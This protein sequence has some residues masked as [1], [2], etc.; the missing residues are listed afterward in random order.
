MN[1]FRWVLA[2]FLLALALLLLRAWLGLDAPLGSDPALWGLSA[3]Q[4]L[5][6][7]L[8][9]VLPGYPLMVAAASAVS[10]RLPWLVG[11]WIST[12]AGAAVP[13]LS[14][15]VARVLGLEWWAALLVGLA[16]LASPDL[17]AFSFQLQPD[18]TALLFLLLSALA[19]LRWARQPLA[20]RTLLF[21]CGLLAM[22]LV[23]E[24]GMVI[25]VATLLL[26]LS[27]KYSRVAWLLPP[28]TA[29]LLLVLVWT[30]VA[31][32]LPSRVYTPLAESP[33]LLKPGVGTSFM[34]ELTG[35]AGGSFR[36][37]LMRGD[38]L[39]IWWIF[40]RTLGQRSGDTLALL[41]LGFAGLWW[42][43]RSAQGS[44]R[45]R[46]AS[47][48][49]LLGLHAALCSPILVLLIIWSH[50]RHAA[51][52]LPL[53]YVGIAAGL[54]RLGK[55]RRWPV[56]LCTGLGLG[57]LAM[58]LPSS[59]AAISTEA[60]HAHQ[61]MALAEWMRAQPGRWFL[62]GVFN[63]INLHLLWPRNNPR[64][65]LPGQPMPRLWSGTD[66]RTM[67]VGPPGSMPP[68]FVPVHQVGG[69]VVYRLEPEPGQE[70]PCTR[71]EPV[72]SV[73]F[74][75][76]DM[77]GESSPSC[78]AEPFFGPEPGHGSRGRGA[79]PAQLRQ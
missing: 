28:A 63:E 30:G 57:S 43:T 53:A 7:Q 35:E 9:S 79:I 38:R 75:S 39:D 29:I 12:L 49:R 19:G 64:L 71:V 33:L 4:L 42:W 65:V 31:R 74:A 16:S 5:R 72:S 22:A 23:R 56:L 25:L 51:L 47:R 58:R 54:Q 3:S 2:W 48:V 14:A 61:R 1:A 78:Q 62:G 45:W 68:P 13:V 20:G 34:N 32:Q 73:L 77:R 55:S 24:H 59:L 26:I 70:R 8:P 18:S 21:L 6:G 40:I 36:D 11:G 46:G 15:G 76:G 10:G 41:L 52:L 27:F 67:W 66:W 37:A 50:R 17:L 60:G 69:L 44:V